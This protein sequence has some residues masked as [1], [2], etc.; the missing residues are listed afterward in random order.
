MLLDNVYTCIAC[1]ERFP[2]GQ[3]LFTLSGG[4]LA[5]LPCHKYIADR[6][7]G[8]DKSH[9][10]PCTKIW[11]NCCQGTPRWK[12]DYSEGWR[13]YWVPRKKILGRSE[14]KTKTL[15][16]MRVAAYPEQCTQQGLENHGS[17]TASLHRLYCVR[18]T[19]L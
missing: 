11:V 12:E 4:G 3:V 13:L 9:Y 1:G 19:D 10:R 7:Y 18:W 2:P 16:N 5:C 17:I 6:L 15:C 8:I 14:E